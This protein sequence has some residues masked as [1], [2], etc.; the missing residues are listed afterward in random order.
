MGKGSMMM[1]CVGTGIDDDD[2]MMEKEPV[3]M[4]L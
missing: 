2:V 1:R 4:T 3:M